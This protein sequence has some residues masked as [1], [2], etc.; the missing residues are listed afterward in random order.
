MAVFSRREPA[1]FILLCAPR[2]GSTLLHTYL[3]SHPGVMSLGEISSVSWEV[4]SK[5]IACFH[6]IHFVRALGIKL[7]Y[8]DILGSHL[9]SFVEKII[10]DKAV[11]IIHLTREDEKAQFISLQ[12]AN[13]TGEWSKTV[14]DESSDQ[15]V[16]VSTKG[17]VNFQDKLKEERRSVMQLLHEHNMIQVTYEQLVSNPHLVLEDVQDFL[18]VRRKRLFTLLKKQS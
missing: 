4:K 6:G 3:N 9:Q 13:E 16:V 8:E 5:K 2:T 7:F 1:R 17:F 14:F 15:S 10:N 11:R 18:G 12:R